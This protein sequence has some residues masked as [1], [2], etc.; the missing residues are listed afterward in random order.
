MTTP[1]STVYT[2]WLEGENEGC[3][4]QLSGPRVGPSYSD[5][6]KARSPGFVSLHC[7][8]NK[9]RQRTNKQIAAWTPPEDG[10]AL[11]AQFVRYACSP[12]ALVDY[13]AEHAPPA[14]ADVVL[15]ALAKA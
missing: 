9:G 13:I 15:K 6:S 5:G 11:L 14:I 12:A 10:Q 7:V 8:G 1:P 3:N 2:V 4:L